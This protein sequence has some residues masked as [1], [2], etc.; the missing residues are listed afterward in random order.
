[1][2]PP[3]AL[4]AAVD[5][6]EPSRVALSFAAR[7]ATHCEG[8]MHVLH[9]TDPLL[10]AAAE[11]TG[12]DLTTETHSELAN[13][14]KSAPPAGDCQVSSHVVTGAAVDA[15]CHIA[16][17]ESADLIVMGVRGM[18]LLGRTM[19]GSTTEGVLRRAD[20]SVLVVPESWKPRKLDSSDLS[21]VG[22]V[23]VGFEL[24][25]V[26]IEAARVGAALAKLLGTSFELRHVVPPVPTLARWSDQ[27]QAAL[28]TR[29]RAA[30]AEIDA[31]LHYF[32]DTPPHRI[33]VDTGSVPE[34]LASAVAITSDRQP[35]L[36]LGRRT[37]AERGGAPGSTAYRVLSLADAPVLMY[38]P[39]H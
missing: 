5:F 4:L 23:I 36:V 7:L 15:I 9:V 39:E 25:P 2:F 29:I 21:G 38:L 19:F 18:S 8:H 22:P 28:Q 33:D 16:E 31:A 10:A 13:F 26:A 24:T 6:S 30:R 34:S 12:V 37:H 17:R 11:H 35:I 3:K 27:A 14:V 1:M 32:A 20:T